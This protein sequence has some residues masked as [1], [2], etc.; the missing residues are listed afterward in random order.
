MMKTSA[1][2]PL[3]DP[4]VVAD[5]D[6]AGPDLCGRERLHQFLPDHRHDADVARR[7]EPGLPEQIAAIVV[8]TGRHVVDFDHVVGEGCPEER[9]RHLVGGGDQPRPD[10]FE[11]Q[12]ASRHAMFSCR[13]VIRNGAPR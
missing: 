10:D 4:R 8:E 12:V 2:W 7:S 13:E 11:R 5:E 9:R 6:V 1:V 3:H